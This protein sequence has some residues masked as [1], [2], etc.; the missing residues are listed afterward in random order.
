[1]AS[2]SSRQRHS[3]TG[4]RLIIDKASGIFGSANSGDYLWGLLGTTPFG[5]TPALG[6]TFFPLLDLTSGWASVIFLHLAI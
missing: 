3:C 4:Q 2:L 5:Q 1:M 6:L